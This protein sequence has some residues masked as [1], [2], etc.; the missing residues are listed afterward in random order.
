MSWIQEL[1]GVEKPIIA[2][3]HLEPLPGDPA[4]GS[5]SRMERVV[6][7]AR[8]DLRAL[9]DGGVDAVLVSNEFSLPYQRHMSFV[10]PAAMA[11]VIGELRREFRVPMG[12]DCISDGLASIE[13][14]AAVDAAFVRGT[15]SGVYV[16]DGGFYNND[17]GEPGYQAAAPDR[18][19]SHC[20]DGA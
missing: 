2:M 17:I 19:F 12:V 4:W 6:E 16:G 15:F 5:D 9:Q 10:T 1:F 7:L 3:L 20:E 14:A 11:R 8:Q 18:P 13:L